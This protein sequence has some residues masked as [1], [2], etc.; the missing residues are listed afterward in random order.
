VDRL[1][2]EETKDLNQ[3][4]TNPWAL[5]AKA[6]GREYRQ[7]SPEALEAWA[8]AQMDRQ[9]NLIEQLLAGGADSIPTPRTVENTLRFYDE[10]VS[11][12]SAAGSQT[13]C[14][15]VCTRTRQCGTKPVN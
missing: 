12:L 6:P 1:L 10:A 14:W 15:I 8:E 11:T 7:L 2:T 5:E 13:A 4:P 3:Q 9:R